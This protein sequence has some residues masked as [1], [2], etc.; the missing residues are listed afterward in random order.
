MTKFL[1]SDME[2]IYTID[3]LSMMVMMELMENIWLMENIFYSTF[4]L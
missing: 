3:P 1:A 2:Y 4:K